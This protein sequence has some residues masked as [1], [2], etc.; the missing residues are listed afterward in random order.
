MAN[1]LDPFLQAAHL[2]QE[3]L[4]DEL[5]V[6]RA[7]INR[8]ANDH[9]KLKRHRA[10]LMAPLLEVSADQLMLNRPPGFGHDDVSY[11]PLPEDDPRWRP[12]PDQEGEA[13]FRDD[14][15]PRLAGGLPELDIKMGAGQGAVGEIM[16]LEIN[17]QTYSGHKVL[18]EWV[19]PEGFLRSSGT[20]PS[21]SIVTQID[22]DS[23]LPNY[24]PGDR[25]VVD[26]SQNQLVSDGVYMISDGS[27]PPQI[28]RLQRIPFST[29]VSIISDNQAYRSFEVS[30]DELVIL[31]KI[32]WHLGRR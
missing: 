7:T 18:D 2:T 11:E 17:G 24:L 29:K 31:G 12:I 21:Q 13:Y 10:E 15:K 32:S 28:K 3:Q 19:F 23:M 25:A 9:S 20:S 4:G 16:T 30:L 8:L 6:S 26:L 5:G 14:Y 1:W 27:S 22:G